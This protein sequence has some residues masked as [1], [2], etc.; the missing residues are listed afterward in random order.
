MACLICLRLHSPIVDDDEDN[1]SYCRIDL[2]PLLALLEVLVPIQTSFSGLLYGMHKF[3]SNFEHN[4]RTLW[5]TT[6]GFFVVKVKSPQLYHVGGVRHGQRLVGLPKQ[7][8]LELKISCSTCMTPCLR[9]Y[10]FSAS[11][12]FSPRVGQGGVSLVAFRHVWRRGDCRRQLQCP[13]V[14]SAHSAG[15]K[16]CVIERTLFCASVHHLSRC[17]QPRLIVGILCP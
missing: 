1:W 7:C 6:S 10:R 15:R 5:R 8:Q 11:V 12:S 13:R 3:F 9:N 2:L 14:S 4:I 17:L 16:K